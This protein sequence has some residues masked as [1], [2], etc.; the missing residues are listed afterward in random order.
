MELR[1]GANADPF[2]RYDVAL[3]A[4][5]HNGTLELGLEE[6]YLST[7]SLPSVTLRGGRFLLNFGKANLAHAHARRFI[8]APAPLGWTLNTD[9]LL[10][11][12]FSIDYLAPLPF[13][14]EVNLQAVH[15]THQEH[16]HEAS[17]EPHQEGTE[18]GAEG[19]LQLSFAGH[20]KTFFEL[21]DSLTWE[22]GLSGLTSPQEGED[23]L[24]AWG[25]DITLKWVPSQSARYTSLEWITEYM[26]SSSKSAERNGVYSGLRYQHA[27]QWMFQLRGALLGLSHQFPQS[28]MRGDA[29]LGFAPS[30]RTAIRLQYTADITREE[31]GH[32]HADHLHADTDDHSGGMTHSLLLQFLV[33]IGQHPAHTY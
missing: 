30:E 7:I 20:L 24:I 5:T 6:A 8:D 9:H 1:L 15:I 25:G 31:D 28:K 13:F 11:T 3:V 12:G 27:Q 29:L 19:N 33:S 2:F 26:A 22:L 21:S 14:T 32:P 4:H 23:P 16:D 18:E 17:S 10:G